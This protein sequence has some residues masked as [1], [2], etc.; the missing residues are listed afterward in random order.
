VEG[1]DNVPSHGPFLLV[2][3]HRSHADTPAIFA[4]VPAGRRRLLDAAA[5]RDYFFGRGAPRAIARRIYR[6]VPVIRDGGPDVD[7]LGAVVEALRAGRGV[8]LYPEGTRN[9]TGEPAQFRAGVGRLIHEVP[10]LVVVPAWID[11]TPDVLPKGARLPRPARVL[12]RFGA[13]RAIASGPDRADWNAAADAVREAVV[14][15]RCAPRS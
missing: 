7:P 13:A 11:G 4:A 2:A 14:G 1:A 12:V 3:N 15:L 8:V 6:A 10:G 5:A 9:P